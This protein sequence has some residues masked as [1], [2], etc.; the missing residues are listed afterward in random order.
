MVENT[1]KDAG[2]RSAYQAYGTYYVHTAL[3]SWEGINGTSRLKLQRLAINFK[4]FLAAWMLVQESSTSEVQ[5]LPVTSLT[6]SEFP[7]TRCESFRLH[8]MSTR[9]SL[10]IILF[11]IMAWY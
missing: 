3:N 10:E 11:P 8:F 4:D 1:S 2:E 7:S 5:S 6:F 9:V